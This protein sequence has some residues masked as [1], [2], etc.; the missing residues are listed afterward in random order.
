MSQNKPLRTAI[1]GYG[2]AGAAF[3]APLIA[4]TADMEVAAIVTR[5]QGRQEQAEAD[6]PK[7]KI[8]Y[9][10][11]EVF[12]CADQFDL[13]VVATPNDTHLELGLASIYAG[14]PVVIDKP[15]AI[16]SEQVEQLI[17]ASTEAK[18]PI[19]VFQNRR[20]DNDFLTIKKLIEEG[21]LGKITRMESR[22]ERYRLE[23][24]IGGWRESTAPEDGGGLLFD[25]GSHLIDQALVL[26][27]KPEKVYAEI[28][29]RRPGV[30]GDDDTFVAL[31]FA[32]AVVVHIWVS[33]LAPEVGPRFRLIGMDGAYEKWGLDPQ[34]NSLKDGHRPGHWHW[35]KEHIDH[36]G[37]LTTY[38]DGLK[39]KVNIESVPGS[40]QNYYEQ[41]RDAIRL[42]SPVPVRI[43]DALLCLKVIEAARLSA[44]SAGPVA[45][46]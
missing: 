26:F 16:S 44:I 22:F 27:G 14:I 38:V 39:Q 8:C 18:V 13:V 7:A 37:K 6:F 10:V 2:L 15:A 25:L 42:G 9:R 35:G 34:E 23:P 43:E 45:I 24:K 17:T 12:K 4:S 40:Y 33:M 3:H 41:M 21:K 1:I 46:F 20:W 5:S 31:H 36:H 32:N 28:M 30:A 19:S 29:H 11:D